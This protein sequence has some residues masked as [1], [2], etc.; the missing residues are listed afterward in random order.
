MASI[1]LSVCMVMG[2]G[3]LR[4]QAQE[5]LTPPSKEQ[6]VGHTEIPSL[7]EVEEKKA[8][9]STENKK[10]VS[11]DISIEKESEKAVSEKA[12]PEK[13]V[14]EKAVPE[15]AVLE[16]AIPEK[17]SSDKELIEKD[18]DLSVMDILKSIFI[19]AEKSLSDEALLREAKEE[20]TKRE[21]SYQDIEM[22][23][24]VAKED[25]IPV[26]MYHHFEENDVP[27]GNG[28]I[29][30]IDE[31]E[32]HVKTLLEEGYTFISLEELNDILLYTIE[33]QPN[34]KA[35]E[36]HLQDKYICITVDDG[37]RSNYDL[38][39]PVLKKYDV[40]ADISVITSRIHASYI[41]A[42]EIPKLSWDDLN[43][44]QDSGLV[45]IY[46]HTANH[47]KA[48]ED[49]ITVFR[50]T[51]ERAEKELEQHL[52]KRSKIRVLTYPNGNF[53]AMTQIMLRQM[54]FD[55]QLTIN[56]GVVNRNT[57]I[58]EIPRITINSGMSGKQVLQKIEAGTQ[59][60]FYPMGK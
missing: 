11:Q 42:P 48:T 46:N 20:A 44:M 47:A 7:T 27:E 8:E 33:E 43:E 52:T 1:V 13:T 23:H 18:K 5:I 9:I 35:A 4:A 25:Y 24:K 55:L 16:K 30:S 26:L 59:R 2:A 6:E 58:N 53:N 21:S 56:F 29:V 49:F 17:D 19:G 34:E 51:V 15:K 37:Y 57:R 39:Y 12:V 3:T 50:A 54:G 14:P 28:A 60:T 36:L 40:K 22:V 45:K 32:D 41:Q 38:M 31:F 10:D